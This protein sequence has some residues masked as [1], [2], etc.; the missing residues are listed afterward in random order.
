MMDEVAKMLPHAAPLLSETIEAHR[1]E[2]EIAVPARQVQ[3]AFPG[4]RIGSYPYH[5]GAR[6]TTRLVLRS[7][8]PALLAAARD[9]M[10]AAL[11]AL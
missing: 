9:A 11:K 3:E 10:E 8:D 6:F 5:D 1:G 7:R 4:V 2:G